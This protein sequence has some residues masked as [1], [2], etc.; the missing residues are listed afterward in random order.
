VSSE[1]KAPKARRTLEDIQEYYTAE[2]ILEVLGKRAAGTTNS[3]RTTS[4]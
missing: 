3:T 1:T 4:G 2:T